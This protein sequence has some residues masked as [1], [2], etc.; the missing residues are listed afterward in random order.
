MALHTLSLLVRTLHRQNDINGFYL[1]TFYQKGSLFKHILE[2]VCFVRVPP[3]GM[4]KQLYRHLHLRKRTCTCQLKIHVCM[5]VSPLPLAK[6]TCIVPPSFI[7]VI[8]LHQ[9]IPCPSSSMGFTN[10]TSVSSMFRHGGWRNRVGV[11]FRHCD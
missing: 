2:G 8:P 6:H 11:G 9:C 7:H 3:K 5:W 1:Q 10:G 4:A